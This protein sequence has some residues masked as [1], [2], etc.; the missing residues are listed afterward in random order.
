MPLV[1][2]A[3][4]GWEAQTRDLP[5]G[6]HV[7]I[8]SSSTE[9]GVHGRLAGLELR[10]TIVVLRPGP[11][12]SFVFL[13]RKPLE[14]PT[15]I[16]QVLKT[17]TGGLNISACRVGVTGG[18]KRSE[19]AQHFLKDDG[20]EDRESHHWARV[21]H[22]AVDI[23]SGRWPPNLVLVHDALC[24]RTGTKE[25]QANGHW[26]AR[27]GPGGISTSGHKGQVGLELHAD[28]VVDTW[29]CEP[30][31]P[32]GILDA[33]SGVLTSGLLAPNH[34]SGGLARTGKNGFRQG[35]TG[36]EKGYGGDSGGASRFFPQFESPEGVV[37]W[38]SRLV[39]VPNLV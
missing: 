26:P 34:D 6:D 30:G 22:R 14:E 20:T 11:K 12:T 18:T 13:F 24:R 39:G 3:T 2:T 37:E 35:T 7:A 23:P 38:V 19:Q 5:P 33:Q 8:F 21:G 17:G 36:I 16:A 4:S 31:C 32:I 25:V 29:E 28:E 15:I 1:T 27:R 10:D 9:T